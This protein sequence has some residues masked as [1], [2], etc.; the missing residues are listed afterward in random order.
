MSSA[1]AIQR[2]L[3]NEHHYGDGLLGRYDADTLMNKPRNMTY[4]EYQATRNAAQ[5]R[6]TH[7]I[8]KIP[9]RKSVGQ[10]LKVHWT[11]W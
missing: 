5:T 4:N 8:I 10:L 9:V 2:Y 6:A 11:R 3:Q 7:D 1:S